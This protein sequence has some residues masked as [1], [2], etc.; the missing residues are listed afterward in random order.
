MRRPEALVLH[1]EPVLVP[2]VGGQLAPAP[3]LV[4]PALEGVE[5]D[6]AHDGIDHVFD[7]AGEQRLPLLGALG[8][9]EQA[10]KG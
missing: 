8:F 10:A 5:L 3:A 9:T 2:L 1:V 4:D 6:L 7:F